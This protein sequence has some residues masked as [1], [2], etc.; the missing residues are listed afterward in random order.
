MWSAMALA[1]ALTL[2]Q[3][4]PAQLKLAN[5]RITYGLLGA[6]RPDAKFLPGDQCVLAFD[7]EGL[8]VDSHGKV[9]YSM[10]MEFLTTEGKTKFK[11][12]EE[13]RDLEALNVLGGSRVP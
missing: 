1:A 3:G 10:G 9:K 5:D 11:R 7:I 4:Q 13:P 2:A 6:T 8:Q 12:N